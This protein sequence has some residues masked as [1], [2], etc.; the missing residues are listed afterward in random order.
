MPFL[1]RCLLPYAVPVPWS[2]AGLGEAA[3]DG[4]RLGVVESTDGN[5]VFGE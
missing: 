5:P 3:F 2:A 4:R 1:F